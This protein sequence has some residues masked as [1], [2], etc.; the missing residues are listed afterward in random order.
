VHHQQGTVHGFLELRS[1]DGRVLASGDSIQVA[2]GDQVVERVIFHFKDGSIDDETTVFSQNRVFRL[3]SDHRIQ[4]GPF[5]PHPM[6]VLIDCR[7][8]QV[9]V[10]SEG[11][12]SKEEVNTSHINLPNDLA[13]GLVPVIVENISV[14]TQQTK[15]PMLVATPKT[16]L[17]NLVI[18]PHAE[19]SFSVVGTPE[20]C[21]HFEIK[22]DLGGAAAIAAPFVGKQPPNI[23]LWIVVGEAPT[24]LREQGQ[25]YP[26]GPLLSIRL[27]S[28]VWT[29]SP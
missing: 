12:D 7:K 20:K 3:I 8:N 10:R 16:R 6:D 18:S 24:F 22:I 26:E 28:P 27:A 1:E 13:N 9:T 15:V 25:T 2:H 14:H 23:Q 5:F 17:V 4:K 19:E 29:D 11:K 21:A